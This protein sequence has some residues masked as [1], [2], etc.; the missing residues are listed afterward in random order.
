MR[1]LSSDGWVG[2]FSSMWIWMCILSPWGGGFGTLVVL[3]N[4]GLIVLIEWIK[5]TIST[6]LT[7]CLFLI[8][9]TNQPSYLH[10]STL[11]H[12]INN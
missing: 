11:H 1:V 12:T 9:V 3:V 6:R 4:L 10:F 2:F 8:I 7:T 5:N